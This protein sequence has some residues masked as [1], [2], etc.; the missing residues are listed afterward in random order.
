MFVAGT[1]QSF[2]PTAQV[3]QAEDVVVA[4]G[5][6]HFDAGNDQDVVWV[7]E[8]GKGINRVM[9]R[10]GEE[11]QA[12]VSGYIQEFMGC[13]DTVRVMGVGVKIAPIPAWARFNHLVKI[14]EMHR[15]TYKRV[16]SVKPILIRVLQAVFSDR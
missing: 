6:G 13:E 12:R 10:D 15:V 4:M 5:Q 7:A 14:E 8:V 16:Y 3:V 1:T 11:V 9:V 2:E